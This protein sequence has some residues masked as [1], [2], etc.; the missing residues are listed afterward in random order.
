[1]GSD[2]DQPRTPRSRYAILVDATYL[3]DAAA[4]VVLHTTCRR[5]Y[6]A[7]PAKLIAALVGHAHAV[8]RRAELLRVYWHDAARGPVPSVDQMIAAD[9]ARVKLRVGSLAG[10]RQQKGLAGQLGADMAE[11]ARNRAVSD[12]I[13][14]A[15]DEDLVPAVEAA[16][17]YGVL[18]HLWGVEPAY[19]SN[20]AEPLLWASD[21]RA[22]LCRDFVAPFF[23][24]RLPLPAAARPA[25]TAAV[26]A[27]VPVQPWP[28]RGLP[29]LCRDQVEDAGRRV[30]QDWIL[31]RG[32][33]S[34]GELLPGPDL[35]PA[36]SSSLL[37][38]AE[39]VLG[40]PL[41]D[42]DEAC[43]WLR[44]AFFARLRCLLGTA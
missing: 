43:E 5:E 37:T 10:G 12:M 8:L 42:S 30:A 32:E 40:M 14:V 24:R 27:A 22:E 25:V 26:T 4:Q 9:T 20:Q 44:T 36:V 2:P 29:R 15:G 33:E 16:Q 13:L 23:T 17:S 6:R 21:V 3:Y 38:D 34:V 31:T 39:D 1:M 35:H 28:L 41:H 7:E 11:L 19:G 18:V